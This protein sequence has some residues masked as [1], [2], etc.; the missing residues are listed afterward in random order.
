MSDSPRSGDLNLVKSHYLLLRYN[1]YEFSLNSRPQAFSEKKLLGQLLHINLCNNCTCEIAELVSLYT[2]DQ[3]LAKT[4][5][6]TA[7][8]HTPLSLFLLLFSNKIKL[9]NITLFHINKKL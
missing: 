6:N 7:A 1:N 5:S 2:V 4:L 3:C 8:D 9:Q